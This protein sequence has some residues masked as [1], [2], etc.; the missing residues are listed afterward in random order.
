MHIFRNLVGQHGNWLKVKLEGGPGTNR[1]AIGARVE[2]TAG[3]I[4]QVQDVGGGYG[5]LAIQHDL[6]LHFGLGDSCDVEKIVVFWPDEKRS[7]AEFTNIRG[8]YLI[9]IKQGSPKVDYDVR[10][11]PNCPAS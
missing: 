7:K 3:G 11:P 5:H 6:V 1:A 8:N 10:L 4:T 9:N 2:V